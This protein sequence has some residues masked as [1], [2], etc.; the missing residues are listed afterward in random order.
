L[1]G[2]T[3]Q[4]SLGHGLF[5]GVSAYAAA[6]L[7]RDL[8][9]PVWV[10]I[11][12]GGVVAAVVGTIVC[13]PAFRLRGFYLGLVTLALPIMLIGIVF[14]F[15][16]VTGGELGIY[17]AGIAG[18]SESKVITF[19]ITGFCFIVS[20]L[21]MW[22]LTDTSSRI[23]RTGLA[24]HAIREDEITARASGI[25]TQNYKLLVFMISGFFAGIAG[26]LYAHVFR[27]VGPSTLELFFSFQAI[28]WTIFGGMTTIY[29][30]VAG[31]FILYP[32]T[33]LLTMHPVGESSR[34]IIQA[35]ILILVLLFMPEG[36]TTWVRDHIEKKCP[37]CK[38]INSDLRKK[39]R[40]CQA[41]LHR[42][43]KRPDIQPRS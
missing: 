19:Y 17:G 18:I 37:R 30:P 12:L 43:G 40:A 14:L 20:I 4:V 41:D 1:C 9:L 2:F 10:T 28:V 7:S 38:L 5:F 6:L 29:G 33:E 23:V 13:I 8:N 3:G 21:I 32:I 34:F 16:N 26:G 27:V 39:C 25:R 11:P 15:P 22:K 24:F 36:I 35:L 31:V 42:R